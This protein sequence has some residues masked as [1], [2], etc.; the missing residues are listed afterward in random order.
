MDNEQ[1]RAIEKAARYANNPWPSNGEV[2]AFREITTPAAVLELISL[3]RSTEA[4]PSASAAPG[5]DTP[6]FRSLLLAVCQAEAA[7]TRYP[8]YPMF[9]AASVARKALIDH[10]NGVITVAREASE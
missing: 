8:D 6:E 7:F 2:R 5:I 4:K 1:I 10:I 9:E 3:T